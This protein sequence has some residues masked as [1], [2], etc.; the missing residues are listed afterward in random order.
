MLKNNKIIRYIFSGGITAFSVFA[1]LFLL[2]NK[3]KVW[4][5]GASIISFCFGILLSFC[6]QKFFTFKNHS[7]NSLHIQFSIFVIYNISMLGL[8]TLLMYIAVDRFGIWYLGS[9]VS[10]TIFTAFLNYLFFSK[11]LFK[12]NNPVSN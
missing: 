11:V 1:L 12:K 3:F 9:Q 7:T 2:V 8:N 5:L 4:Y 6:L 10:I